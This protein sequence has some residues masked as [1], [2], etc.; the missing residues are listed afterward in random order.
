MEVSVTDLA[1]VRIEEV[2]RFGS[3]AYARQLLEARG[4]VSSS[5][6]FER[7]V[8]R[9]E[10]PVSQV[11]APSEGRRRILPFELFLSNAHGSRQLF[12]CGPFD[13]LRCFQRWVTTRHQVEYLRWLTPND[14]GSE[15]FRPFGCFRLDQARPLPDLR[16]ARRFWAALREHDVSV[17]PQ[18]R[19]RGRRTD[20]AGLPRE[21]LL[22]I[23]PAMA[24]GV[25]TRHDQRDL[26][27][28][29]VGRLLRGVP[30]SV[31]RIAWLEEAFRKPA[32]VG[33]VLHRYYLDAEL[34]AW[35][36]RH[37]RDGKRL[38]PLNA[39]DTPPPGLWIYRS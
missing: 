13:E 12:G 35:L 33:V 18:A 32:P 16:K 10:A 24:S 29:E 26:D 28:A 5:G 31:E 25:Y 1:K 36:V 27:A 8:E 6:A 2:K 34:N 39:S 11:E 4:Q 30:T 37:D 7:L 19:V 22:T 17:V 15:G 21:G 9:H 23:D 38:I 3:R 20:A 14:S